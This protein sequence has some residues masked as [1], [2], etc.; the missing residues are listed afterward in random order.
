VHAEAV[1]NVFSGFVLS[2]A[3]PLSGALGRREG[4]SEGRRDFIPEQRAGKERFYP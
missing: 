2:G 1:K 3:L 4:E